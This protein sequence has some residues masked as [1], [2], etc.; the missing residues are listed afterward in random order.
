MLDPSDLTVS[1]PHLDPVRMAGR[2]GENV[3]D[4]AMCKFAC[5]LVLL[6]HNIHLKS[7]ADIRS[8]LPVHDALPL[9]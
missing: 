4:H 6:Q 2:V 7:G 3:F 8:D 1:Q 5:R 9:S